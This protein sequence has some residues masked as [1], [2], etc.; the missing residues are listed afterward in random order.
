MGWKQRTID[1]YDKNAKQYAEYYNSHRPRKIEIE[2]AFKLARV[3]KEA[4]VVE[5]GCGSGRDAEYIMKKSSWY[6]GFDPSS[7]LIK[8]AKIKAPNG[9]FVVADTVSY[10]Y[11]DDIDIFFA[12]ASLLH[13]NINEIENVF[14]DVAMSLRDS[15]IVLASFKR[16]EN[17]KKVTRKDEGYVGER[18]FYYYSADTIASITRKD[19]KVVYEEHTMV[20]ETGWFTVALEKLAN[21]D[22]S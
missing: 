17:Y 3:G 12:F 22:K 4:R 15:G 18:A 5:I 13:L 9:N 16:S 6:E 10:G 8:I 11:P 20:G 14:K 21:N 2:K 7:E 19:F 1:A